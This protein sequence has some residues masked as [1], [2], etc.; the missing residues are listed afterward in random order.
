[1]IFLQFSAAAH[2]STT[3]NCNKMDGDRPGPPA[4]R[5][6]YRLS[7]VSW[8]LLKLLLKS[9]IRW[10]HYCKDFTRLSVLLGL[11]T[12]MSP[13][14]NTATITNTIFNFD[15]FGSRQ[16]QFN[17]TLNVLLFEWLCRLT[18]CS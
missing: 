13:P 6:R 2:A 7:R 17:F 8:A 12:T 16:S 3:V 5:N 15:V 18:L 4:N 9:L 10:S 11:R 1:V 14:F